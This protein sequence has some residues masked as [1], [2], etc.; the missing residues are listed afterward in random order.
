MLY[1]D[2]DNCE[3]RFT[4]M[5]IIARIALQRWRYFQIE[6][7]KTVF[8]YIWIQP[9]K[10]GN[11]YKLLKEDMCGLIVTNKRMNYYNMEIGYFWRTPYQQ[12]DSCH[13][14]GDMWVDTRETI[15]KT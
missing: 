6:I 2:E 9:Y 13:K 5:K 14:Q 12:V 3:N 10:E 4:R 8:I 15:E 7:Y 1:K 11:V